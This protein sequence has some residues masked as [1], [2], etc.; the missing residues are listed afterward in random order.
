MEGK[1]IEGYE[2]KPLAWHEF[3][4]PGSREDTVKRHQEF[5]DEVCALRA[6]YKIPNVLVF[7]GS[8][9]TDDTAWGIT[10]A[11]VELGEMSALTHR[12]EDHLNPRNQIS[13]LFG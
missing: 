8:V 5:M 13:H 3:S 1:K 2:N 12:V 10:T 9:T 4:T 7:V 6:K 11:K